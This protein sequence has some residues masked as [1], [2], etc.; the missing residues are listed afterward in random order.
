M[1]SL[2]GTVLD[3]AASAMSANRL[4]INTIS[5]N[6]ANAKTTRTEDGGPYKRRDVVFAQQDLDVPDF[7][8]HLDRASLKG[9]SVAGVVEDQGPPQLVYDPA[10]PDAN[11][12]T[13]MVEL[14]NVNVVTEMVNMISASTA[15]KSAAEIVSVSKQMSNTLRR[16]AQR[17]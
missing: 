9:V 5:S 8:H 16:L 11:A 14:P 7:G 10:H 6:I 13:G 2:F 15:Y 1:P 12:E 3:V 17:F 4:R